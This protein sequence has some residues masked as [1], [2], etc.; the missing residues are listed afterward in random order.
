MSCATRVGKR[1]KPS[2]FGVFYRKGNSM[3]VDTIDFLNDTFAISDHVTFK[4]GP[5][6]LPVAEINNTRASATVSVLGG[7]VMAF[8]P[9]GQPPVLWVSKYSAYAPGK[10]IRGGIPVCWP[11]FGPHPTDSSKPAHGFVRTKPW[12]V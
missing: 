3:D 2:S 1:S 10:A 6:D 12:A 7:H 8:Q 5:G 9:H 4:S 11:W